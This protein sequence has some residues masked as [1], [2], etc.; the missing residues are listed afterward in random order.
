MS[1]QYLGRFFLLMGAALLTALFS[2]EAFGADT[3]IIDVRRNI[4]LSDEAPVYKDFYINGGVDAGLKKNLIVTVYR[5]MAIKD[6][7]G[8]QTSGEIE[9]PVGQLRVISVQGRLAVA[10]EY[11]LI[12][13]DDEPMLEQTAMMI[14]DRLSL[15]GSFIDKKRASA[16]KTE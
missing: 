14:G 11:K 7:T 9:I 8:T 16:N 12:P 6:A 5:K 13:R 3:N 2:W 4:P 15:E 1:K 10:R